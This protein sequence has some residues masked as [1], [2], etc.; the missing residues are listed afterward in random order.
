MKKKK[1]SR[2]SQTAREQ[3]TR[4]RKRRRHGRNILYYILFALF[5]VAI[6]IVLSLTVFFKI[7]LIVVE[8]NTMYQEGAIVNSA[9]VQLGENL[10]RVDTDQI[11]TTLKNNY[12]YIE[13]VQVKRTLPATLTIQITE[14]V[15]MGCFLQEDGSYVLISDK[16]RILQIAA[17]TPS[18]EYLQVSGVAVSGLSPC[19]YLPEELSEEFV[20]FHYLFEAV[21]ATGFT[22]ITAIDL[23][24]T[25][26]MKMV[27]DD[28][29]LIYLGSEG[30][31]VDKLDFARYAI[32]NNIDANFEGTLDVTFPD[33]ARVRP[34]EI[35]PEG[36]HQNDQEVEEGDTSLIQQPQ[37]DEQSGSTDGA[38]SAPASVPDSS[39]SVP[40]A[41]SQESASSSA[42]SSQSSSSS[43]PPEQP[44]VS[45]SSQEESPPPSE[46]PKAEDQEAQSQDE[47][48]RE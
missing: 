34:E 40:D 1:V 11:E 21:D 24:D 29:I 23:S 8:G 15:P 10:F 47:E 28:R 14:A 37:E 31:L 44:E 27:Y 26:N 7:E 39:Q 45:S 32:E 20:M 6:G 16:G 48:T 5:A 17:G 2:E 38:S 35:H 3:N 13:D 36:Y 25:L 18:Q 4:S 12:P 22:G 43:Q 9:N 46:E 19:Q 30:D 33:G 42:S 41:G